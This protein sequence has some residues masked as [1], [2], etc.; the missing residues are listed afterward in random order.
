MNCSFFYYIFG[1]PI[2]LNH[3]NLCDFWIFVQRIVISL[4]IFK[5]N[6]ITLKKSKLLISLLFYLLVHDVQS[7]TKVYLIH[8]YAGSRF[9]LGKIHK[10]I[11]KEGYIT[12]VLSYASLS[13][14]VDSVG[15]VFFKKIQSDNYDTISFV[16]HSM[17]ALVVRSLYE[18]LDSLTNFPFM[19]RIVMIAPPN[20]GSPVADFFNRFKFLKLVLGPNV[21][22]LTT[23]KVTGSNKYPVPTCEVGLIVGSYGG[24][25][26]LNVFVNSDNDGMLIPDQTKLGIEKDIV[27]VKTWHLGLLFN[28]KVI[29][30]TLNFLK[31]GDFLEKKLVDNDLI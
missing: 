10:A 11:E 29:K 14:D 16:T 24:K 19:Y 31:N 1:K 20:N 27:Y 15:N 28:K 30:Y 17:G 9:E 18:H 21:N 8:G 5:T 25:K 26:G 3:L 7:T 6:K 4:K 22:N 23:N 12:E 13:K 2:K